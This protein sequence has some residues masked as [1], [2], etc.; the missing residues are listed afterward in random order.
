[1]KV[2]HLIL[3]GVAAWSAAA[4]TAA[5]ANYPRV[6]LATWYEVDS[7]WPQHP[8][9]ISWRDV[10]GIAVDAQDNVWIFTRT[11]PTVQKYSPGGRYLFGWRSENPKAAAHGLRCDR[12]GNIWLT[13][14]GLHVVRKHAPDGKVLLTLGVEGE[15]GED[16]SHF[17]MPTDL[18]FAPNGDVFVADGYGN[19]RVVHF[20][21]H[22]RFL[23]AWG[24]LGTKPGQFS[25]PHAIG[26]DS[27]GRVYVADRNNVRVQVFNTRGKLLDVWSEVLVPWGIWISPKDEIWVCGSSPMPWI[28]HPKYPTAP[29]GCPPRDQLIVKFNG[30]GRALQLATFPKGEDGQEKPG[31]LNWLHCLAF[32]SKG[33]VFLGDIIGHRVQKF[34]PRH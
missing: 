8:P 24:T 20:D 10:P 25:I 11:N 22:G 19:S 33:N 13:D 32:D 18:T 29:L 27:K 7:A 16:S 30:A 17:N 6:N 5:T 3:L 4:A 26:C 31:E 34:V 14:V 2:A 15:W 28:T 23:N 21:K 9:E 1:M 12:D